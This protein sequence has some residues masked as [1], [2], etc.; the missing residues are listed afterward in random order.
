MDTRFIDKKIL[1]FHRSPS[2]DHLC[3]KK[4]KK[5]K[6]GRS[7]HAKLSV[8]V[9]FTIY[10]WWRAY[11]H[12]CMIARSLVS[13][14]TQRSWVD[15]LCSFPC[16]HYIFRPLRL[17]GYSCDGRLLSLIAIFPRQSSSS[18]DNHLLRNFRHCNSPLPEN[19][20]LPRSSVY[21]LAQPWKFD[22]YNFEYIFFFYFFMEA[23][24]YK[25]QR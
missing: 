18:P 24:I 10:L 15:A 25:E 11:M 6:I 7:P 9:Q 4:K 21:F 3:G 14:I 5:R 8:T 2:L 13:A 20:V 12:A 22:V 23:K 1:Q 19:Y 17:Q 16:V